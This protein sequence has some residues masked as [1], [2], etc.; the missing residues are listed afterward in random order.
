MFAFTT[1]KATACLANSLVDI[2]SHD[3]RFLPPNLS[4][5]P[6]PASPPAVHIHLPPAP[7]LAEPEIRYEE[8]EA[9]IEEETGGS[10]GEKQRFV[11]AL[12]TLGFLKGEVQE[13]ACQGVK[14]WDDDAWD[15]LDVLLGL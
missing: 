15:V 9:E 5:G 11:F 10:D 1:F 6:T 12:W 8:E 13:L 3:R 7:I 2:I 4:N 14:P